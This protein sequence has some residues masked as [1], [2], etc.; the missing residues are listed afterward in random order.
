MDPPV[1]DKANGEDCLCCVRHNQG[2]SLIELMLALSLGLLV[3]VGLAQLFVGARQSHALLQGQ[4]RLQESGRYALAF[5]GQSARAAGYLGCNGR[6]RRILNTLN[7]AIDGLFA[8][9]INRHIEAFDNAG[10]SVVAFAERAGIAAARIVPGTDMVA[11]RRLEGP[12]LR[13]ARP[14]RPYGNPVVQKHGGFALKT[15]DF[16]LLGNCEQVSLFRITGLVDGGNSFTLLRDQGSGAL[17]NSATK[18]LSDAAAEYAPVSVHGAAT[19]GRVVTEVYFI[20]PGLSVDGRGNRVNSLW[21]RSGTAAPAELVEGINDLQL[22]YGVDTRPDDGVA[23]VNRLLAYHAIPSGAMI[24]SLQVRVLAQDRTG[25]RS[26]SQTFYLRN[27]AL[28]G[29]VR[30]SL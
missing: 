13:V 27:T 18:P 3:I 9:D 19:V 7:G 26:F 8:L 11:F 14:V 2:F 12:L 15:D 29:E 17:E 20:A 1:I 4:S 30:A 6:P 22:T 21:R 5:I 24:R 25:P 16:A 10:G 28:L 23:T